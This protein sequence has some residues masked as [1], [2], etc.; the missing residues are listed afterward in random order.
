MFHICVS[1]LLPTKAKKANVIFQK[2]K[3]D[4]SGQTLDQATQSQ[5]V[6]SRSPKPDWIQPSVTSL[7]DPAQWG[8]TQVSPEV[9]SSIGDSVSVRLQHIKYFELINRYCRL[10]VS[11]VMSVIWQHINLLYVLMY[12]SPATGPA[13]RCCYLRFNS[14]LASAACIRNCSASPSL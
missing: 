8:W 14:F 12:G 10:W 13:K 5:G 9:S 1:V 2:S 6:L 4:L 11:Q 3:E 7:G